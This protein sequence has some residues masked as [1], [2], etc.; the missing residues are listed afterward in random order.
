MGSLGTKKQAP[1]GTCFFGVAV[2]AQWRLSIPMILP[3]MP[4]CLPAAPPVV[5]WGIRPL[6]FMPVPRTVPL[7]PVLPDTR[8][9]AFLIMLPK[10]M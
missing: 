5:V 10:F 3:A 8:P 1:K 9:A 7:V 4:C 2:V 6:A